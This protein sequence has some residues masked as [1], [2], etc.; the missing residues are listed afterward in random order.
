[1]SEGHDADEGSDLEATVRRQAALHDA[2]K[3]EA[4]SLEE[5][6]AAFHAMIRQAAKLNALRGIDPVDRWR[7]VREEC[8]LSLPDRESRR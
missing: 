2:V 8:R 4:T 7:R 3:L 5:A 6:M 1:M